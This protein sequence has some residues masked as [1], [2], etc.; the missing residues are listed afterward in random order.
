MFERLF[1]SNWRVLFW[2][3]NILNCFGV[4]DCLGFVFNWVLSIFFEMWGLFIFVLGRW[5]WLKLSVLCE[6]I[7]NNNV[8]LLEWCLWIFLLR[9]LLSWFLLS[10]KLLICIDFS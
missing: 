7:V 8:N 4:N 9:W 1:W 6:S 10:N 2:L 3:I 5:N